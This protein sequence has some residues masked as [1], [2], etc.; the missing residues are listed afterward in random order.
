MRRLGWTGLAT[1]LALLIALTSTVAS[2]SPGGVLSSATLRFGLATGDAVAQ[3]F[4]RWLGELA[5]MTAL[6]IESETWKDGEAMRLRALIDGSEAWTISFLA[7]EQRVSM[8]SSLM[9]EGAAT[10]LQED[11]AEARALMAGLRATIEGP[12]AQMLSAA[13]FAWMLRGAAAT[14]GRWGAAAKGTDGETC[15]ALADF[16]TA[17]A[18]IAEKAGEAQWLKVAVEPE[19]EVALTVAQGAREAPAELPGVLA[20]EAFWATMRAIAAAG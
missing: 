11:A 18:D 1:A 5:G 13:Q 15:T 8:E 7:E 9:A 10:L 14:T 3:P 16:L 17:F 2:A 19:E 4:D 6:T 20:V 12:E